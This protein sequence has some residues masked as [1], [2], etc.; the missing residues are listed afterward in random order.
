MPSFNRFLVPVI[1]A[2]LTGLPISLSSSAEGLP[3]D[4]LASG[5]VNQTNASSATTANDEV[6][7][8]LIY[9]VSRSPEKTADAP[10]A[11]QVI[12]R[13]DI[14]RRGSRTLPDVLM[15]EAGIFIQHT[16]YG[17]G[18]PIIRG[19]MGKQILILIDG[20]RLN[21][22]TYRF[23]PVQYLN[24]I[25]INA[26]ERIEVIRGVGTVLGSDALGGVINIITQKGTPETNREAVG[27][28][29]YTR[30][31]SADEGFT[32]HVRVFGH[33]EHNRFNVGAT[34]RSSGDLEGG[35]DVGTQLGTGYDEQAFNFYYEHDVSPDA[36]FSLS[37]MDLEQDDVPRTDRL[38][39]GRNLVFDFDPQRLQFLRLNY[40]DLK[41][42]KWI[43]SWQFSLFFN[44]QEEGRREILTGSPTLQD[45]LFDRQDMVGL[46]LE[47]ES[48]PGPKHALVYGVDFTSETIESTA[49]EVD[50]ATGSS[51]E[52][53]G[54]FTDGSS[55]DTLAL[56]GQDRFDLAP[57]FD[58]I[59]GARY[60]VVSSRGR[61]ESP[62]GSL[63][64]DSQ[65]ESLTGTIGLVIEATEELHVVLNAI[66]GFRA[67]SIDD[68][69]VFDERPGGTEIPNTRLRPERID[70]AEAGIKYNSP[71]LAF[72]A[73]AYNSKLRNLLVRA[74]GTFRGLSFFDLNG[75]RAQDPGEPDVLQRQNL[76]EATIQGAELDWSVR[77]DRAFKVFGNYTYTRGDDDLAGVPLRRIPPAFGLLGLRWSSASAHELWFEVVYRYADSQRRLNPGDIDDGRVGPGG[78]DGFGVVHLRG[79]RN[80]TARL[81]GTLALENV[82][83]EKYKHHGSGFYREGFQV[84][85]QAAYRF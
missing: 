56:Y 84:V 76:G 51:Q 24:T 43:E 85:A 7:E 63:E 6:D 60:N 17:G 45:N 18:S 50:L 48:S 83:D 30:Y 20:S 41:F 14:W 38:L 22:S 72:T 64:L 79:G 5:D 68:L 34:F 78:T 33:N 13:E 25:D 3:I 8:R 57:R 11:V 74:P 12:T 15:E 44:R 69:S 40:S 2:V 80:L 58:L 62:V 49:E 23:G 42:R 75:N 9:S 1:M 21:T 47:F 35:G 26:V 73:F 31:S 82:L 65:V 55:Y 27:G 19:Q 28:A 29:L 4:G 61:E 16:N 39:S 71:R 77:F 10:R 53:R 54:Q 36:V 46:N 67:P 66:H 59:L 37:Y 52:L 81:T 32:G 70:M